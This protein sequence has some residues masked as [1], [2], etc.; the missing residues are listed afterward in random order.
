MHQGS[1]LELLE[2]GWISL[3]N[4]HVCLEKVEKLGAQIYLISI[5]YC[6]FI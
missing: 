1:T 3:E 6:F 4:R 5:S 2:D